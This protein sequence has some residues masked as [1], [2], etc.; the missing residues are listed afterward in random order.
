M[1]NPILHY[2]YDPFC[3]WCYGASPM[4]TAAMSIPNLHVLPHGVGMLSGEKRQQMNAGWRDF[5]RPHEER[6]T[7]YSKQVF[8]EPY[9]KGVLENTDIL[10]DSSPP[11]AAMMVAERLDA[12]GAQ[13][14]K[15][16]QMAYYQHGRPIADIDTIADIA[17]SLGYEKQRFI[18]HLQDSLIAD[19][20][21]HIRQSTLLLERLTAKGFPAF[22]LEVEGQLQ[23]LPLGHYLSRPARF[24]TDIEQMLEK[25]CCQ[26]KK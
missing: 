24:K 3:G 19:V 12:R 17:M 13:M 21:D 14:L 11:I 10:L 7:F 23:P 8:A 4:I 25:A 1:N 20:D 15:C 5:V 9:V 22:A 16:L 26:T 2:L 18:D 6:I